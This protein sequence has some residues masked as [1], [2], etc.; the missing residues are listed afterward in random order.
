MSL[1]EQLHAAHKERLTRLR[2]DQPRPSLAPIIQLRQ[3]PKPFAHDKGWEDMWFWDL[4][5]NHS[6][7]PRQ[8]RIREIQDAACQYFDVSI[9]DM[10][11][12]R[13]TTA[14]SYPRQVAMYLCRKLTPHGFAEIGRRFGGRDHTTVIHA[15]QKITGL[16]GF[17]PK[18]SCDVNSVRK[19]L[20]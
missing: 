1:V 9:D 5:T 7:E 18:T 14:I 16:Y 12:G 13:R 20:G 2:A 8:Y 17:E 10:L 4:I 6:K 3:A 11:S 15:V 19:L